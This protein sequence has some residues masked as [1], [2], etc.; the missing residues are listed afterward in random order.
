MQ[1]IVIASNNNGKIRE[2][3]HIFSRFGIE[4]IPQ[5]VL[6]VPEVEEPYATFVENSLHKARH[7]ARH[8]GLAALADDSGLCVE[9]L[10]GAP[11]I[12]SARYAGEPKS[13]QANIDKL[14]AVLGAEEHREAYF[15]CSLVFVRSPE[16]PQP[17]I[18][19]GIFGGQ[20]AQHQSGHNGHGYDPIFWLPQ[21]S[22]TVADLDNDLKNQISHRALALNEM[23][24]KLTT[25]N[26][27][28][29]QPA[30]TI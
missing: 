8:T 7:C 19:E 12:F 16:D 28:Q 10:N 17:I 3:Q 13:D 6:N 15:Y 18:A 2:F 30:L 26:L 20:I 14:L 27:I 24:K 29:A 22:A 23:I 5:S 9:V 21:Y 4:I 25:A 11:G 1:Q